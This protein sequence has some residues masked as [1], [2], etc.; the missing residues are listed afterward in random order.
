MKQ[1]F[2]D[3]TAFILAGGQSQRMGTNKAWLP[4]D[5]I[6]MIERVLAVARGVT[7]QVFILASSREY[8]RLGVPLLNDLR[9][10]GQRGAGPLAG[11]ESALTH[12]ER[13]FA[14]VLA[15]DLPFLA[16]DFLRLL[17][18]LRI[19]AEVV[20]PEMETPT[21]PRPQGVCAV[22]SRSVLPIVTHLLDAGERR[23]DRLF[24]HA[25]VRSVKWAEYA[26]LPDAERLL[27]NLNTPE[28]YRQETQN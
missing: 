6:P 22:Y 19:E 1:E 21:G 5:G 23:V 16:E 4:V 18:S 13:P 27:A 8:A 25:L 2:S 17:L 12:S 9:Q 15:C 3:V 28:E 24:E 7:D 10:D 11:I 26:H 20:L 14:L